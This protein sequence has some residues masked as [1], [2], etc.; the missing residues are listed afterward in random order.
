M[1]DQLIGVRREL[2]SVAS[3]FER[4][5]LH[6]MSINM[7]ELYQDAAKCNSTRYSYVAGL[8]SDALD[9]M[10]KAAAMY[11][12]YFPEQDEQKDQQQPGSSELNHSQ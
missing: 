11:W 1:R 4:L 10:K 7:E 6:R 5:E 3:V 12:H 2:E 8:V 9:I